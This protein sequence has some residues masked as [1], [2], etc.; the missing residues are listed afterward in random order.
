VLD[1]ALKIS[2]PRRCGLVKGSH[3]VVPRIHEERTPSFC[4][5]LIDA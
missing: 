4:R 1:E 3:I 2:F 5:T